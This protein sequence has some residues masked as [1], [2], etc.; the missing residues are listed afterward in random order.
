MV[1]SHPASVA[2]APRLSNAS[3]CVRRAAAYGV[4]RVSVSCRS[5]NALS[6]RRAGGAR[7]RR[8]SCAGVPISAPGQGYGVAPM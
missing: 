3:P 4:M 1:Q 8:C 5:P 6:C 2:Q 7:P